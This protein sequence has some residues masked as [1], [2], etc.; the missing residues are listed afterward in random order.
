MSQGMRLAWYCERVEKHSPLIINNHI[1]LKQA[2]C[3]VCNVSLSWLGCGVNCGHHVHI[4]PATTFK[5]AD[6]FETGFPAELQ[7]GTTAGSHGRLQKRDLT[8]SHITAS[9][10]ERMIEKEALFHLPW[11]TK[12]ESHTSWSKKIPMNMKSLELT[13]SLWHFFNWWISTWPTQSRVI[14]I[15]NSV[16]PAHDP[17][18]TVSVMEAMIHDKYLETV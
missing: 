4:F 16:P 2:L 7:G 13:A 1:L 14:H 6:T 12:E 18:Q 15:T 10:S 11:S 17:P 5:S 9:S 3:P 8:K